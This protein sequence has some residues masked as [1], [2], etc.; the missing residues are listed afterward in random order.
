MSSIEPVEEWEKLLIHQV[1]QHP[2]LWNVDDRNFNQESEKKK[3][4]QEISKNLNR[5]CEYKVF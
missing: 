3:A 2:C 5:S 4:W 1:E